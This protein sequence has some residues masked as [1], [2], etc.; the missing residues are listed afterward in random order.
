MQKEKSDISIKNNQLDSNLKKAVKGTGIVLLGY[1]IGT[2]LGL[3]GTI[4]IARSYSIGY[5][6]LFGLATFV[7]SFFLNLS[8]PPAK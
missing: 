6:G 1:F 8:S 4:L 3:V 2:V 5:Y 7:I